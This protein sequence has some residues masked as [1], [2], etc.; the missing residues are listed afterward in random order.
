MF[1]S[2]LGSVTLEICESM[3][4]LLAWEWIS[5][6]LWH[7]EKKKKKTPI[8]LSYKIFTLQLRYIKRAVVML[9]QFGLRVSPTHV[10]KWMTLLDTHWRVFLQQRQ[11]LRMIFILLTNMSHSCTQTGQVRDK[12][13]QSLFGRFIVDTTIMT[14]QRQLNGSSLFV[15]FRQTNADIMFIPIIQ[16]L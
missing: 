14:D 5:F 6:V 13:T 16:G 12:R 11:I 3:T 2:Q 8:I 4:K 15:A 10:L 1:S 7:V 9:K